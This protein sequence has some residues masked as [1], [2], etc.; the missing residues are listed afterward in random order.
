[1]IHTK[2]TEDQYVRELRRVRLAQQMLRFGVRQSWVQQWTGCSE[3]R[4]RSICR[5]APDPIPVNNRRGP[6]PARAFRVLTTALLRSEASAIVGLA[7]RL[8]VLPVGPVKSAG[9]SLPGLALGEHLCWLYELYREW[10]PDATLT[11]EQLLLLVL[12]LAQQS[13]LF[14]SRCDNCGGFLVIDKLETRHHECS[15]CE[16]AAR[17]PRSRPA[18]QPK[19]EWSPDPQQQSLF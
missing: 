13:T 18:T 16:L 1:M 15:A 5:V 19:A 17:R 8:G 2:S 3:R 12:E 10:V 6:I 11:M 9:K 7:Q 4:I 14:L